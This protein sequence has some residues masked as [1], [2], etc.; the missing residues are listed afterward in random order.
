MTKR[1]PPYTNEQLAYAAG[2]FDG[3]GT[4][5]FLTREHGGGSISASIENTNKEII[6]Y[7]KY[8]FGGRIYFN[9]KANI[10]WKNTYC[11]AVSGQ[12]CIDFLQLVK[13]WVTIKKEQISL[14]EFFFINRNTATG[15]YVLSDNYKKEMLLIK[16]H[17]RWLNRRGKRLASDIE[18]IPY[19]TGSILYE[20]YYR[21]IN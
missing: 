7:F 8:K 1:I 5:T 2:F 13:P 14:A 4:V 12:E 18:P 9:S 21:N 19:K 3:E 20:D 15:K 10:N 11:W 6:D 16:Q 17:F